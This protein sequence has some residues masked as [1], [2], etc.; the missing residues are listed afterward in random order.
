MGGRLL[1]LSVV[2]FALGG[3][4][5]VAVA[6]PD[7]GVPPPAPD[8]GTTEAI[9]PPPQEQV[10][11][12]P[13]DAVLPPP[14]GSQNAPSSRVVLVDA[15]AFALDPHVGEIVTALFRNELVARG[16]EVLPREEV[17]AAVQAVR[18]PYPPTV[19]D[20]RRL[21]GQARAGRV[22]FPRVWARNGRYVFD[23]VQISADGTTGYAVGSPAVGEEPR[24][25][26]GLLEE[27]LAGRG[28]PPPALEGAA[29]PPPT[30][31]SFVGTPTPPVAPPMGT[32]GQT[33]VWAEADRAAE[34]EPEYTAADRRWGVEWGAHVEG[35]M[36]WHR[37]PNGVDPGGFGP[38]DETTTAPVPFGGFGGRVEGGS[39]NHGLGRF[40][41][42][43]DFDLRA[44]HV[45][46]AG[47]EPSGTFEEEH[48]AAF[49]RFVPTLG[50]DSRTF[51]VMGGLYVGNEDEDRAAFVAGHVRFGRWD[52]FWF[53][54]SILDER[55]C[56][57]SGCLAALSF[58]FR[59]TD[60]S[61]MV[62]GFSFASDVV[63]A[64][65]AVDF[66]G[67][68]QWFDVLGDIAI[69]NEA[70]T[71]SLGLGIHF[72]RDPPV[73]APVGG[74]RP[75]TPGTPATPVQTASR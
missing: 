13:G 29:T 42:G 41:I 17:V 16:L 73:E 56:Y 40:V 15:A 67:W 14:P 19:P 53:R 71:L 37:V 62:L 64:W 30:T 75:A 28:R 18:M 43:A 5:G 33:D 48:S 20:L 25:I 68:G 44:A 26:A 57:P 24:A 69:S 3:W 22:V 36:M 4:V 39:M 23:V 35:G 12:P 65:T 60:Y 47:D 11:P 66:R 59:I 52:K 34:P 21:G 51:E 10:P 8:A 72:P 46:A 63:R 9:P 7:A 74:E 6:Q 31:S 55:G 1:R 38:I 45:P 27:A 49:V 54:M 2:V 58:G 70:A 50:Y 61:R 32:P